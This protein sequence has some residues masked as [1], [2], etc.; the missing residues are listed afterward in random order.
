MV[1]QLKRTADNR[2]TV[3]LDQKEAGNVTRQAGKLVS[4]SGMVPRFVP[5]VEHGIIW[6][7]CC[8]HAINHNQ[9]FQAISHVQKAL[10]D[11]RYDILSR[12]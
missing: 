7:L 6:I 5:S 9:A 4:W 11:D 1:M 2:L 10:A 8:N 3:Y 12:T